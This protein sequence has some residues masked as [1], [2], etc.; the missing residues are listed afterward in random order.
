MAKTPQRTKYYFDALFF[1]ACLLL[2]VA[3]AAAFGK[4]DRNIR[5]FITLAVP[6]VVPVFVVVAAY[7]RVQQNQPSVGILSRIF[8]TGKGIFWLVAGVYAVFL[9]SN[10]I[11]GISL[12]S[13]MYSQRI[14]I[15]YPSSIYFGVLYFI[16]L[17]LGFYVSIS[18][19]SLWWDLLESKTEQSRN[20]RPEAATDN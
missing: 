14:R 5:S 7:V 10:V 6:L 9:V 13:E 15:N 4:E 2:T 3:L 12:L 16:I 8:G 19:L 18:L 20:S 17:I 11:T 1:S